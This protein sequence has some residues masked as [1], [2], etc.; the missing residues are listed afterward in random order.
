MISFF[1]LLALLFCVGAAVG[2][3]INVV[4]YRTVHSQDWVKGRSR[5][6]QCGNTLKWYDMIPLL[7]FAVLRGRCRNCQSSIGVDHPVVEFLTGLLFVWWYLGGTLFFQ[8]SQNPF[9][10]L[11]PL[12]W[13]VVGVLLLVVF[14]AD[15]RFYII[16][17]A[18]VAALFVVTIGYRIAL[19]WQG[20]MQPMDLLLAAI[21]AVLVLALFAGLW[22]LTKGNG[23]GLGDVK[24][25]VP[26]AFL[27]GWPNI[28]IAL[29]SAFVLGAVVGI[30]L[31]LARRKKF[32][33]VVP[34]GPFLVVG[35]MIAL[36]W[37]DLLWQWYLNL[38]Y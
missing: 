38:L 1:L 2:S 22:W 33:Q 24:F 35:T 3:F 8:L 7:S 10:L 9:Q 15:W 32:G 29:L 14:F 17:D 30:G 5:C 20:I 27:V 11:Q 25:V 19:T 16:P 12:F 23:M 13:L 34:F 21:G 4:I 36:V 28:W 18:A 31:L 26:M 37:G 6:E